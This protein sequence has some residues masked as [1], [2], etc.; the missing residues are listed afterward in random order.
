MVSAYGGPPSG[1]ITAKPTHLALEKEKFRGKGKLAGKQVK[2]NKV[3]ARLIGGDSVYPCT[4]CNAQPW[5]QADRQQSGDFSKA[6][7][8]EKVSAILK[9]VA[10]QNWRQLTL[11][12][13]P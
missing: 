7:P 10:P 2:T 3:L 5:G 13:D 1:S 8:R 9:L 11:G 6:V 4:K 12:L